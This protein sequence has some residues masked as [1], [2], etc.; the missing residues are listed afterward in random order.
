MLEMSIFIY[1]RVFAAD[2]CDEMEILLLN[3]A[4]TCINEPET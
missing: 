3:S 4:L 2:E 1:E